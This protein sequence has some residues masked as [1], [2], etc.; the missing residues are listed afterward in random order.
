MET[1]CTS[2]KLRQLFVVIY[3]IFDNSFI[4][5]PSFKCKLIYF[6]MTLKCIH[7]LGRFRPESDPVRSVI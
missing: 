2:F 5:L 7:Y 1:D 4:L 6:G 3:V